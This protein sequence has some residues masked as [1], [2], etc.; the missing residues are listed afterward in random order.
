MSE[1]A[2]RLIST[3]KRAAANPLDAWGRMEVDFFFGFTAGSRT[4]RSTTE[5][6][7]SRFEPSPAE[8]WPEAAVSIFH[9]PRDNPQNREGKGHS[10]RW[11]R[12]LY[13]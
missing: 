2:P 5:P 6:G 8:A 13:V 4:G 10:L 7:A 12:Q 11:Q 3:I 9:W 1:T